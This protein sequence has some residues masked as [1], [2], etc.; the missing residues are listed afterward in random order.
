[1][2]DFLE[3]FNNIDQ[4]INKLDIEINN[5]YNAFKQLEDM[6]SEHTNLLIENYL[7]N[8]KQLILEDNLEEDSIT[9]S[10]IT[11][12]YSQLYESLFDEDEDILYEDDYLRYLEFEENEQHY[13]DLLDEY[14]ED[15]GEESYI[16]SLIEQYL[17][18]EKDLIEEAKLLDEELND[19]SYEDFDFLDED[20]AP[21]M[22]L[23]DYKE[24][25]YDNYEDDLVYNKM[26]RDLS[27]K[28]PSLSQNYYSSNY[29]D[30]DQSYDLDYGDI[31]YE[32]FS[33]NQYEIYPEFTGSFDYYQKETFS[34]D[35]CPIE[36]DMD[37]EEHMDFEIDMP[38]DEDN[39]K[40]L[41]PE[42]IDDLDYYD[43]NYFKFINNQVDLLM[44]S[45]DF[46]K[47]ELNH[48]NNLIEQHLHEENYLMKQVKLLDKQLNDPTYGDNDSIAEAYCINHPE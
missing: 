19:L 9:D 34:T 40:L 12:S 38:F 44:K 35:Y 24:M 21:E 37:F 28:Y 27:E 48:I 1:M 6:E 11:N 14:E 45:V 16:N 25:V 31:P 18:E 42:D 7:E 15:M 36:I 20:Y 30:Y 29:E 32:D 2:F 39:I 3:E 8:E 47:E 10:Y 43:N 22:T 23:E 5:L 33:G 13:I 4:K 26:Y 17:E 41:Q 46:E